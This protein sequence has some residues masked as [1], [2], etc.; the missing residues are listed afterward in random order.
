MRKNIIIPLVLLVV[1]AL[2][3]NCFFL[4][5]II[6]A[7]LIKTGET[8]FQARVEIASLKTKF[9]NLSITISG[10][11]VA[12]KNNPMRNLLEIKNIY[13]GIAPRPLLEGKFI[14]E[15]VELSGIITDTARK[16]SGAL[17]AKKMK[18]IARRTSPTIL[19]KLWE[20]SAPE[21]RKT[22]AFAAWR[23]I[24]NISLPDIQDKVQALETLQTISRIKSESEK[25]ISDYETAG[26]NLSVTEIIKETTENVNAARDLRINNVNDIP[27]AESLIK[28]LQNN[29]QKIT[30]TAAEL[31]RLKNSLSADLTANDYLQQINQARD[32]D[33]QNTLG[34]VNLAGL[35]TPAAIG[36]SLLGPVWMGKIDR[37]IYY[38][39][40][41]RNYFPKKKN[42]SKPRLVL[43]R[44]R[45]QDFVFPRKDWWPKFWIKKVVVDGMIAGTDFSGQIL[46]IT[47]DQDAINQ[48]TLAKIS[49]K[50]KSGYLLIEAVFDYRGER[51]INKVKIVLNGLPQPEYDLA[52][53]IKLTGERMDSDNLFLLAGSSFSAIL[54]ARIIH[55]EFRGSPD[56]WWLKYL[57]N[58]PVLDLSVRAEQSAGSFKIDFRSNIDQILKQR[59][60]DEIG[61]TIAA[62]R[63]KIQ[64]EIDRQV[65]EKQD[66]LFGQVEGRKKEILARYN[67]EIQ[68]IESKQKDIER[69]IEET[70]A[71]IQS[72][73]GKQI[74]DKKL[75]E[76]KSLL[77]H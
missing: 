6:R 43:P 22:A 64:Q 20:K 26:N 68:N 59:I 41:V 34:K 47:S 74:D 11:A 2:V 15:K 36:Q 67:S 52:A 19:D 62:Y 31:A 61:A 38:F 71:R 25:K 18:K 70:R 77:G 75:K 54:A 14:I 49:G 3:F 48:P 10:L 73:A 8:I 56:D 42:P 7:A 58:I 53:G 29:Q 35:T 69:A 28:R 21:L 46:D 1:L 13:F 27:V 5:K 30:S 55:P 16:D 9:S 72:V 23:E 51:D 32:K 76:L 45:G 50:S 63:T 40:L 17:P 39:S 33:Y 24:K 4:D 44:R 57:Q 37:A 66:E 65:K 12:D 60:G